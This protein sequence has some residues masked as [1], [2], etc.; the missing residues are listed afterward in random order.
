MSE[1]RGHSDEAYP[2][3]H[4][5][6]SRHRPHRPRKVIQPE[7]VEKMPTI[8]DD[9]QLHQDHH[10]QDEGHSTADENKPLAKMFSVGVEE[11]HDEE[12]HEDQDKR[13][14]KRKKTRPATKADEVVSVDQLI[15]PTPGF[16]PT[17]RKTPKITLHGRHC[18][19]GS[20]LRFHIHASDVS[21]KR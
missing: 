15:S 9:S 1:V 6:M 20:L 13:A 14:K 16:A 4:H 12:G 7:R 17:H 8:Q 3:V 5:V 10:H 2:H 11:S 19:C 18:I 21:F